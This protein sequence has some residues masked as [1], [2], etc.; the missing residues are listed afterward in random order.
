MISAMGLKGSN[1]SWI[2]KPQIQSLETLENVHGVFGFWV[3]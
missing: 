1:F 2:A 3:F